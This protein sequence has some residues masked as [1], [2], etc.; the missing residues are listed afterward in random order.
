MR[1]RRNDDGG[2]EH[3]HSDDDLADTRDYVK[4]LSAPQA[5]ESLAIAERLKATH[6][7][8]VHYYMQRQVGRDPL[9]VDALNATDDLLTG[10]SIDEVGSAVVLRADAVP[11]VSGPTILCL[12]AGNVNTGAFDPFVVHYAETFIVPGAVGPY[13]IRPHGDAEGA[14]C[15]TIKAYVRTRP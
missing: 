3:E 12:Q 11:A 13:T 7:A 6:G 10:T 9:G 1:E 14:E 2:R 5:P 15:A 8:D 4:F